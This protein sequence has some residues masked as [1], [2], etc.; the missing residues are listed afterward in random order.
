MGR[1][2]RIHD[3]VYTLESDIKNTNLKITSKT[4]TID[5]AKSDIE[6][7]KESMNKNYEDAKKKK[8]ELMAECDNKISQIDPLL[9][10]VETND[11]FIKLKLF[12]GM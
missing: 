6:K 1:E 4:I 9:N 8:E 7:H 5:T 3:K 11:S 10:V 12:N 2:V